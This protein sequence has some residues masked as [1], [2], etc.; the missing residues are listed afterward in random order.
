MKNVRFQDLTPCWAWPRFRADYA[1][2]II[3]TFLSVLGGRLVDGA[4]AAWPLTDD[5]DISTNKE[6]L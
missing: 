6:T 3:T 5:R 2:S 1:Y 4:L